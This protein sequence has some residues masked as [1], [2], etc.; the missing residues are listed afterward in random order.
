MT[1]AFAPVTQGVVVRTI[2]VDGYRFTE[3]LHPPRLS[4]PAHAHGE[5]AI[6]LVLSGGMN[7]SFGG[8]AEHLEFLSVLYKPAAIEH[9]NTYGSASVRSFIIECTRPSLDRIAAFF[10]IDRHRATH[11]ATLMAA[12]ALAV[13]R[14]FRHHSPTLSL[15]T[16]RLMLELGNAERR[17]PV[18]T[19]LPDTT[20]AVART[21]P[22]AG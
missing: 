12:R 17:A 22:T 3:T 5:A 11:G 21:R 4:L 2:Y 18:A 13:Y 8:A 1:R 20:G 15:D 14:S 9:R 7:E 6:T 19:R 10:R 16:E